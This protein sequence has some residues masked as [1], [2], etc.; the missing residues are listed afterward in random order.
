MIRVVLLLLA[1][2]VAGCGTVREP[3]RLRVDVAAPCREVPTADTQNSPIVRL[4]RLT[5]LEGL[6]RTALQ[7]SV[8]GVLTSSSTASLEAPPAELLHN[9]LALALGCDGRVSLAAN[10][11]ARVRPQAE[12]KGLVTAFEIRQGDGQDA[13]V[14]LAMSAWS[15]RGR[16][17]TAS[18][19][20][21]GQSPVR[22]GT[23][24]VL[25][26]AVNAAVAQAV[27]KAVDWIAVQAQ[28]RP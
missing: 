19:V 6:E 17:Q 3:A 9:A 10:T 5:S 13:V 24:E 25:A 7:R 27:G 22:G 14:E 18:T 11:S 20:V 8:G 28:G 15:A 1:V 26:K 16:V 23:P 21:Q 2:C 12:I 4:H